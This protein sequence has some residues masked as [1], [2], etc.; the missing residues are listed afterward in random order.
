MAIEPRNHPGADAGA[1]AGVRRFVQ[2]L[3]RTGLALSFILMTVGLAMKLVPGEHAAPAVRLFR[4]GRDSDAADTLMAVGILVLAAT[5]AFR[6][7]SLIVL[8]AHERD[9]HFVRVAIAVLAVLLLAV[10]VGHG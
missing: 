1:E 4:L 2:L 9:W 10:A 5:P 7:L 6:V 3:L 8:W